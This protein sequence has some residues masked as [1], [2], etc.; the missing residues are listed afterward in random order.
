[1]T[2]RANILKQQLTQ[3]VGLPFA[4]VLPASVIKQIGRAS[5]NCGIASNIITITRWLRSFFAK[6]SQ[7]AI[8]GWLQR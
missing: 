1:M 5:K 6:Y 3:S 2:N 4:E 7:L 8:A